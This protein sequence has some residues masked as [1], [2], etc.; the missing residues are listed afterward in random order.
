MMYFESTPSCDLSSNPPKR[1]NIREGSI[2]EWCKNY[3]NNFL[4]KPQIPPPALLLPNFF[5]TLGITFSLW[6]SYIFV[7]IPNQTVLFSTKN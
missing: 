7:H 6:Q 2:Q 1:K 4:S 5:V 3:D